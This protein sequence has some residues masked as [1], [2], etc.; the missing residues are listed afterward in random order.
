MDA[1]ILLFFGV[2]ERVTAKLALA[3][4]KDVASLAARGCY[5]HV[6]VRGLRSVSRTHRTVRR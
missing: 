4:A 1:E 3:V 5:F 6:V 2:L